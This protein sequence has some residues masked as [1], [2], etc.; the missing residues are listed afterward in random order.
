[1]EGGWITLDT[2]ADLKGFETV[3]TLLYGNSEA[4]RERV[5]NQLK[6]ASSDFVVYRRN[7]VPSDYFY[8]GN[9]RVGDPVVIATG[10]YAIR[11]HRPPAGKPDAPP[12]AGVDGYPPDKV[13]QMKAIFFAAGPDILPGH[14]V[15]PFENVNVYPWI[16][17]LLGLRP[18]GNDGNL[19]VLA[20]TL[21]DNGDDPS[22]ESEE[23]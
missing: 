15:R 2:M 22:G 5:Y 12:S 7:H 16:A 10:P 6:K 19:N 23:K 14:T 9:A 8:G 20:G 3:G 1:M 4:D 11:A 21:G 17:H 13:P 18:P